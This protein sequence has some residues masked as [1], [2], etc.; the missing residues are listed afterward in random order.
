MVSPQPNKWLL[1]AA[2]IAI[3]K[4]G[5]NKMRY[6]DIIEPYS[7][8]S[9]KDSDEEYGD[10]WSDANIGDRE[11]TKISSWL[12]LCETIDDM[13]Q[14]NIWK[15]HSPDDYYYYPEEITFE[16]IYPDGKH[17][18]VDMYLLKKLGSVEKK[19]TLSYMT[20][21]KTTY[22]NQIELVLAYNYRHLEQPGDTRDWYKTRNREVIEFMAEN[23]N[24]LR[25]KLFQNRVNRLIERGDVNYLFSKGKTISFEKIDSWLYSLE[26]GL[27][28]A[29][30]DKAYHLTKDRHIFIKNER[31]RVYGDVVF[32]GEAT[33]KWKSQQQL[34]VL[35]REL[36]PDALYQYSNEVFNRQSLDIFIPS[37]NTAIEY[38]GIQHYEAMEHLG[39]EDRFKRQQELDERKRNLCAKQGIRLIEWEY[40][41]PISEDNLKKL[42]AA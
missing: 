41:F 22:K 32:K 15:T 38:Q 6:I 7:S 9:F 28:D 35:T 25:I 23:Y 24:P 14:G 29:I 18:D 5:S 31:T 11:S 16:F 30:M 8:L 21:I 37:I 34:Y 2:I 33:S 4:R 39:G 20:T 27:F 12:D 10:F 42:I 17:G 1:K 3:H 40:D 13:E 19:S 26:E 36:Y